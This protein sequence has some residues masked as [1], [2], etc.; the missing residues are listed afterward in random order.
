MAP[1]VSAGPRHRLMRAEAIV[2]AAALALASA[3][4]SSEPEKPLNLPAPQPFWKLHA[5]SPVI[6]AGDFREQS[7]WNDPCV[8]K[9]EGGYVMYLTSSTKEPFKPPV[10]PFRAVSKDG[11]NWQL[12]PKAPLMDTA[13]TPFT[14][15]ET[16]SVV[17]FRGEY[18]MYYSGVHAA[19]KVPAMEIGYATSPDGV[20]WT[21]HPAPVI[22]SSGNVNEWTGFAVAEP[23]AV[24]V[25]DRIHL[26]FTAMGQ[27]P[28]GSPP[29][30]QN[31]GLA[32]SADGRNFDAPRIALGQTK[33]YPPEAGYP[34]YS[35]P[36]ALVDG[37]TVHLFYDIVHFQKGARPEWRQVALQ[38]A[39]STDGGFTFVESDRPLLRREDAPWARTGEVIGPSA[40]IDGTE[41]KLWFGGHAGYD[42]LANM[43]KRGWK[44]PEFGIGLATTDLSRL[45]DAVR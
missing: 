22:R 43:I 36:S 23:G 32:I 5:A 6:R 12:D 4:A 16:P 45:R 13:G 21:K 33:R 44:G 10:L 27:R 38:H 2:A 29:Q 11:V 28:G 40:V 9:V 30:L 39:V 31:I 17:R 41:V 15:I 35:T 26:Y 37:G 25:G 3:C 7:L 20:N 8:L 1:P 18:H 14:S 24:V 42:E 34:G 19:G